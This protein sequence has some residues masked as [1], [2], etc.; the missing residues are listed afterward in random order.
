MSKFLKGFGGFLIVAG[1]L[2]S[3]VLG[4]TSKSMIIVIAGVI[5][6]LMLPT[7]L[8][9]AGVALEYLESINNNMEQIARNL[10]SAQMQSRQSVSSA[11]NYSAA[12]NANNSI[13]ASNTSNEVKSAVSGASNNSA[14]R[15]YGYL[16]PPKKH[17]PSCD[18]TYDGT[19]SHCP[20]CNYRLRK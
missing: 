19:P 1:I 9:A 11:T 4:A 10:P 3:I 7:L 14:S 5:S 16:T 20:N 13:S 15:S 8:I 6:S 18:K 2:G 17:C 12:S